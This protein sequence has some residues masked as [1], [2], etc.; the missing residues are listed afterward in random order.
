MLQRSVVMAAAWLEI[1]VG[2][3]LITLVDVPCQ[4]LFATKP[5]GIGMPLARFAGVALVGLG[6]SC[7]PPAAGARRSAVLGLFAFNVGVACLLGWQSSRRSAAL[8]CGRRHPACCD[9]GS[10]A[11]TAFDSGFLPVVAELFYVLAAVRHGLARGMR[12][13]TTVFP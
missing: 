4:L 11:R 3:I 9:R 13:H 8:C 5:E 7:L 12:S 10:I 2:G 1:I 6:I